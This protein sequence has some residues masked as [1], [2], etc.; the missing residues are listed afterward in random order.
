M[1]YPIAAA[2]EFLWSHV[3]SIIY[4]TFIFIM[5]CVFLRAFVRVQDDSLL[6][7][8][9]SA[10]TWFFSV[11]TFLV[12]MLIA[13]ILLACTC[14][15]LADHML[16]NQVAKDASETV[17]DLRERGARRLYDRTADLVR[18]ISTYPAEGTENK[19]PEWAVQREGEKRSPEGFDLRLMSPESY[20]SRIP[21]PGK[22]LVVVANVKGVLHFRI[23]DLCDKVVVDT[24][25]T[26]L[27]TQ[28]G[29]IAILQK[30]LQSMWPPHELTGLEKDRL[31]SSVTAIVGYTTPVS[32]NVPLI[33][34][35]NKWKDEP[36]GIAWKALV[37]ILQPPEGPPVI[38]TGEIAEK[39]QEYNRRA[40]RLKNKKDAND[41]KHKTDQKDHDLE[42]AHWRQ[43]YQLDE[44]DSIEL[45]LDA[46]SYLLLDPNG[47]KLTS[48]DLLDLQCLFDWDLKR[49]AVK[50]RVLRFLSNPWRADADFNGVYNPDEQQLENETCLPNIFEKLI[51]DE[52]AESIPLILKREPGAE[53]S[54]LRRLG[55]TYQEPSPHELAKKLAA[56]IER[57]YRPKLNANEI[58]YTQMLIA[59]TLAERP[60]GRDVP[61][62]VDPTLYDH[63]NIL[64][65]REYMFKRMFSGVQEGIGKA[66]ESRSSGKHPFDL[67][68]TWM[69]LRAIIR[70]PI[71]L[72]T[73]CVFGWGLLTLVI[74]GV[75]LGIVPQ[76]TYWVSASRPGSGYDLYKIWWSDIWIGYRSPTQDPVFRQILA[77]G[78]RIGDLFPYMLRRIFLAV[79]SGKTYEEA[80]SSVESASEEWVKER[81]SSERFYDFIGWLLPSIG[82]FGT[83]IGIGRAMAMANRIMT[84]DADVQARAIS[85]ITEALGTKFYTTLVALACAILFGFAVLGYRTLKTALI[86][87]TKRRA[88][89]YLRT[90]V[91]FNT[92]PSSQPAFQPSQPS[93]NSHLSIYLGIVGGLIQMR[94]GTNVLDGHPS[95]K[96]VLLDSYP[97]LRSLFIKTAVLQEHEWEEEVQSPW[98]FERIPELIEKLPP[99]FR[100][101]GE[102]LYVLEIR[103]MKAESLSLGLVG[104]KSISRFWKTI[105][106][107]SND[108]MLYL[109][110]RLAGPLR[111]LSKYTRSKDQE[112]WLITSRSLELPTNRTQGWTHETAKNWVLSSDEKGHRAMRLLT[113]IAFRLASD[114]SNNQM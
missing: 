21:S 11:R 90:R 84:T 24:D 80:T 50:P 55:T 6:M 81:E 66:I 10:S 98:A 42:T 13:A 87:M 56:E 65:V 107:L 41:E 44:N 16:R 57:V 69:Q 26:S 109:N 89:R 17:E 79:E 102:V 73:F 63:P 5:T 32:G 59:L 9:L 23:S 88:L 61:D 64:T 38:P 83:A 76:L 91:R 78:S 3:G 20:R 25:A 14:V 40:E 46:L 113:D 29:P 7:K 70:G 68:V 48:Q 19:V 110:G 60:P 108:Y 62:R 92:S 39:L 114:P 105:L 106:K 47:A 35:M 104:E 67:Q 15:N 94:L 51:G 36:K 97:L 72:V 22:K 77:S 31:I 101:L 30:E 4:F 12:S 45:Y 93:A 112:K 28:A 85:N 95:E 33:M 37:P 75:F 100:S 54:L 103:K 58:R 53:E 43:R 18:R 49:I 96:C 86:L 27:M 8:R 71:Q 99:W 2:L 111:R 34:K 82:F 1:I 52:F 74:H